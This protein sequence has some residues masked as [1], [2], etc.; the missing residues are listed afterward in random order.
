MLIFLKMKNCFLYIK[1]YNIAK[2]IFLAEIIFKDTFKSSD[3]AAKTKIF[4]NRITLLRKL[5][6][7]IG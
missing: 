7:A 1:S 2:K 6:Y 5:V 4:S 3:K